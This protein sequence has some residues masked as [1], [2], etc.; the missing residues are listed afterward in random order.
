MTPARRR[1]LEVIRARPG[2][3]G[4]RELAMALWPDSPGWSKRSHRHATPAGGAMATGIVMRAGTFA[5]ALRLDGLVR[6]ETLPHGRY[7]LFLTEVGRE[8]LR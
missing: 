6:M 8:A 1:A 2:I 3:E 4:G 7:R 5:F